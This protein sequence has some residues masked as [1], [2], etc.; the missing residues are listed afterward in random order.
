MTGGEQGANTTRAE[1]ARLPG[2]L[3]IFASRDLL[4]EMSESAAKRRARHPNDAGKR[5][6][7]FQDQKDRAGDR[8]RANTEC[9]YNGHVRWSVQAETRENDAQPENEDDEERHRDRAFRGL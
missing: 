1:H 5:Q 3:P 4:T 7:E 6:G 2:D 9:C 8:K